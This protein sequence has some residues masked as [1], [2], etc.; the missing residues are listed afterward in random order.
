[1]RRTWVA[2]LAIFAASVA[3]AAIEPLDTARIEQLTGAK[4]K[5]DAK[6]H[7][8]KVSS[9]R[10]DLSVTVGRIKMTPPMGLTTWAAFTGS[11]DHAMVMG[12]LVLTEEQ[13]NRVMSTALDNGLE[14]TALHNHFFGDEPKIMF[15]HVGGMGDEEKLAT[16][17]G[18]IFGEINSTAG[19]KQ[20]VSGGASPA[21]DP[22]KSTI[23]TKKL[24]AIFG[25]AGELDSGVYKVTFGRTTKDH[26]MEVGKTM[27]VN[28]WAAF[29]GSDDQAVVDGDFAMTE[30]ELQNVLKTLR[31]AGLNIVAIHNHMTGEQPRIVFLHF[32]GT[33]RAANLAKGIKAALDTQK[34]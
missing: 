1:M 23:D 13:V 6:E 8:F 11:K 26:G 32:W 3:Q 18:K 29:V 7:V 34:P 22:A 17:V 16:A 20:H 25:S 19:E 30:G 9:P 21:I 2:M 15:M 33:G 28:T 31:G 24:D 12:D 14:V 5:W 27:G 4:G 10:K